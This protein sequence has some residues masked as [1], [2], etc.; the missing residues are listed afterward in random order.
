M[1]LSGVADDVAEALD[2]ANR[3]ASAQAASAA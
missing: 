3:E 1:D 2:K